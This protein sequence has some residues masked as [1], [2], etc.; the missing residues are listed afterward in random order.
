MRLKWFV[1]TIAVLAI[2][3]PQSLH[4]EWFKGN[5]HTHTLNSDG[6][7]APDDVVRWYR[8]HK[9]NFVVITDHNYHTNVSGLNAV[10]AAPGKFL[11]I[12]GNEVS[13]NSEGKPVHMLAIDPATTVQSAYNEATVRDALARNVEAITAARALVVVNH[14]NFMWA[15]TEADLAAVP[16]WHILEIQNRHPGVNNHGGGGTPDT[17]TLWDNLLT[18]GMRVYGAADDDTHH[19]QTFSP[20][21]ANPGRGWIVVRADSLTPSAITGA[22]AAGDFYFSTGVELED[23]R[24]GSG[25]LAVT[26]KQASDAAV[27]YTVE[28]IGAGGKV[29]A[30]GSGL[31]ASYRLASGDAYVRARITNSNGLQAWTQ[32]VFAGER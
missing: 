14:P 8:E 5:I 7:S 30:T 10:F 20:D 18:R 22:M 29:L 1:M 2:L 16:G 19:F 27:R 15:L 13:V 3:T 25:E 24:A 9:Y 4:A 6:D 28:F 11:V 17:E 31:T 21:R 23:V 26:V 12:E 32:P